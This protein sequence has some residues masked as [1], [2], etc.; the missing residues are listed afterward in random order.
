[1]TERDSGRGRGKK[2]LS[3]AS[4][5]QGFPIQSH[6]HGIIHFLPRR[7]PLLSKSILPPERETLQPASSHRRLLTH[8][9]MTSATAASRGTQITAHHNLLFLV[10]SLLRDVRIASPST[11]GAPAHGQP[12]TGVGQ[13]CWA[14]AG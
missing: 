13:G 4:L 11:R 1:M 9:I 7:R 10:S 6:P 3:A 14:G 12:D 8:W 5:V 2:K